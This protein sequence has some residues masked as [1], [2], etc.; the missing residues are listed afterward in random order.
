MKSIVLKRVSEKEK[1]AAREKF[2]NQLKYGF[3]KYTECVEEDDDD[4]EV[5]I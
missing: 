2:E 1:A 3:A 5:I 4:S